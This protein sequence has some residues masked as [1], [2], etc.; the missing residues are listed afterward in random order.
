[1][2]YVFVAG[3]PGS[4]WSSVASSLSDSARINTSDQKHSYTKPGESETMHTGAYWDPGCEYGHRFDKLTQ[5]SRTQLEQE[6]D[7]AFEFH[8]PNLTKIIKSHQ[9]CRYLEFIHDTWPNNSIVTVYR[10][11]EQCMDW[12]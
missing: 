1:M 3:A 8:K 5:F 11:D 4:K 12:W 7:R 10:T 2:T 9:F 6:F